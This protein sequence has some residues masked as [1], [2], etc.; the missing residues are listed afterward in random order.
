MWSSTLTDQRAPALGGTGRLAD[1]LW[2]IAHHEISGKPRLAPRAAGLGLAAALLAELALAGSIGIWPAG[3][4]A[5]GRPEP[6]DGLAHAV[7]G[8][9]LREQHTVRDWLLYLA[10]TAE[11][12]VA[13]R[14]A[15]AGYLDRVPSR[16]PWRGPRWV[17]ADP[18]CAF[19]PVNRALAA[20][21]PARAA[22]D[23]AAALAGLAAACGLGPRV[24]MYAPPKA[25]RGLED[26]A[27]QL[28]PGLRYLI[29]QARAE[30]AS[31][32]LAHRI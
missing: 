32:V 22:P 13:A 30:V 5:G 9:V 28:P 17:P 19:A 8:R 20:L 18:D 29:T 15:G 7:L 11:D 25:R 10:R 16:R 21:D 26:A 3:I 4:A 27:G 1:D 23:T 6:A 14:L 12:D 2:L 31:A 24:L